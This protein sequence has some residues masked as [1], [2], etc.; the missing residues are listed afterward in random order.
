MTM[1]VKFVTYEEYQQMFGEPRDLC[2]PCYYC[3]PETGTCLSL[4]EGLNVDC[5]GGV[6]VLT[7]STDKT[8]TDTHEII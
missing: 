7:N 3:C 4:E 1:N 5:F 6:F 8:E 2:S